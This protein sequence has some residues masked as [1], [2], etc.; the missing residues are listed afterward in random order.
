MIRN[1]NRAFGDEVEF[2]S[3]DQMIKSI[4]ECGYEIP[5]DGLMSGRDYQEEEDE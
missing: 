3:V 2:D 5:A 1:I 4:K